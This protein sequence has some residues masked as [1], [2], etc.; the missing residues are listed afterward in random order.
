MKPFSTG[1]YIKHQLNAIDTVSKQFEKLYLEFGGKLLKDGH[2]QRVLPGYDPQTKLYILQELKHKIKDLDIIFCLNAKELKRKKICEDMNEYSKHA[3]HIINGLEQRG[4]NVSSIVITRYENEESAK[5]AK[6]DLENN[7]KKVITHK[8]IEGYPND[9]DN[10]LRCLKDQLYIEA[11]SR[12]VIV[13]G[14]GAGSGKMSV[15][16]SQLNYDIQKGINAGYA[17]FETFPVYDLPLKHPVNIAYIAATADINDKIMIDPFH[18]E[19]Y[20]EEAVNFNRDVEN[21]EILKAIVKTV[22][23]NAV[24]EYKSP[25][26]MSI[27]MISKG[28]M[29]DFAVRKA[30]KKE[31]K[32]RYDSY[33]KQ[34]EKGIIPKSI[35]NRV[36]NLL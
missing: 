10:I 23:D 3:K 11:K 21:F 25:T 16:M 34:Y 8:E 5:K 4:L 12:L 30:A 1:E 22:P 20:G 32:R 18:L 35:V 7:G 31:I 33:K 24:N 28:I 36:K 2:A 9:I 14:N 29:S 6:E 19:H 15:C 13:T 27:N 17:K 26:D